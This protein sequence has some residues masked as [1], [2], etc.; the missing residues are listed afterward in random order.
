MSA[1]LHD[2]VVGLIPKLPSLGIRMPDGLPELARR[3]GVLPL[4]WDMGG[5]MAL[6]PTGEVVAWIWDEEAEIS[7][8]DTALD[9]NR[10]LFQGAAKYPA[11]VPFLPS[12]PLDATTCGYCNGSGKLSGLPEVVPGQF[13]CFCGG[14]GW[15]PGS[16]V[17]V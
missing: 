10:A 16:V 12:R 5:C 14:A 3:L 7:I 2:I 15:L 9:R 8:Q 6:R 17:G 11:L 13:V 4:T 1:T